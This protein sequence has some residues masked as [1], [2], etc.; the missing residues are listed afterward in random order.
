MGVVLARATLSSYQGSNIIAVSRDVEDAIE[1]GEPYFHIDSWGVW[2]Y[3][4]GESTLVSH[5]VEEWTSRLGNN[6]LL[7]VR[8]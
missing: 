5:D 6:S 8:L 1:I 3:K 2:R 7:R 4:D